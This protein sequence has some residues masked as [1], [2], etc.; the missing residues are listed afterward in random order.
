[1]PKP[2]LI[3]K[4]R[5]HNRGWLVGERAYYE[6]ITGNPTSFDMH[7]EIQKVKEFGV[8]VWNHN[9]SKWD[10]YKYVDKAC[11]GIFLNSN[12]HLTF[13]IAIDGEIV[14]FCYTVTI[15]TLN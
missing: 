3:E 4:T 6:T 15:G 1:M 13:K 14:N 9:Q 2:P 8:Q 7:H 10:R 12:G 11:K 5:T